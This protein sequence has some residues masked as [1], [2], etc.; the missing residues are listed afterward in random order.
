MKCP[1]IASD[2]SPLGS[3]GLVLLLIARCCAYRLFELIQE[4]RIT[5]FPCLWKRTRLLPADHTQR[6]NPGDA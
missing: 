6:R 1:L 5:A 2:R 3:V 4:K